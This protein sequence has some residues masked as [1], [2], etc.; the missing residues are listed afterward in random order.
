METASLPRE[1]GLPRAASPR[2]R[3]RSDEEQSRPGCKSAGDFRHGSLVALALG[4]QPPPEG[5]QAGITATW[6][7]RRPRPPAIFAQDPG[8]G[9]KLS[10]VTRAQSP[11]GRIRVRDPRPGR[12][13]QLNSI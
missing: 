11:L 2:D 6:G 4:I 12:R 8:T 1:G 7:E 3:D 13:H 10:K 9:E 5:A